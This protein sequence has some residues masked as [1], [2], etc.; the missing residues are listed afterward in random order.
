ML[1]DT[2]DKD[3][4]SAIKSNAEEYKINALRAIKTELL[5]TEKGIGGKKPTTI[6]DVIEVSVLNKMC[7]ER[8]ESAD[9]YRKGGR[10]DLAINEE[11]EISIIKT[12]LPEMP[13]DVEVV[14][15]ISSCIENLAKEHQISSRDTG[16]ILK[17]V[18]EKY[19]FINGK[20]VSDTIVA[21]IK[22]H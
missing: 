22:S 10:E 17:S 3:I 12:Y 9:Q 1:K 2:I 7:K 4:Q 6:T 13:S 11:K 21:Y 19:P 20:L 8:K 16:T 5:N 14:N 15:Y 18:K